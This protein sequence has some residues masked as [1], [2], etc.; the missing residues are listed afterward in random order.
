MAQAPPQSTRNPYRD[1]YDAWVI[2]AAREA[3]RRSRELLNDT[4]TLVKPRQ[5]WPVQ[6]PG[7]KRPQADERVR[8]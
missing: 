7:K 2:Q 6:G 8:G 4:K 5:H 3:I 1:P